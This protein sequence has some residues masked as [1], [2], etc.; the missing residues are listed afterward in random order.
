MCFLDPAGHMVRINKRLRKLQGCEVSDIL[1]RSPSVFF[2]DPRVF[3]K[4]FQEAATTEQVE[5][6]DVALV[7]ADGKSYTATVHLGKLTDDEERTT[8][9]LLVINDVTKQKAFAEKML[10]TEKLAALG[11][12][13]GGVAHDFNNLLMAILGNIQMLLQQTS[14]EETQRRL[15]NIEKAVHDGAHTVRRLQKFTE[16]DRS[17]IPRPV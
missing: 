13:A 11:T 4:L 6:T 10:Q 1:G 8:G 5:M 9:Y 16:R 7:G 17:T 15:Q 14:D 12:M 2:N 3:E